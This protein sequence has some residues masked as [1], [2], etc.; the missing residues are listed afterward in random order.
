ML[1]P[2]QRQLPAPRSSMCKQQ[3]RRACRAGCPNCAGA[4]VCNSLQQSATVCNGLQRS[5]RSAADKAK[6]PART[7]T[8]AH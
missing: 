5:A 2:G 8:P 1:N 3:G 7:A 6:A 4:T